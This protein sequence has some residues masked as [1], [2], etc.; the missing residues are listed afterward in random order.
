MANSSIIRKAK[1]KIVKDFIKDPEIIAAID[2]STIKPNEPEKLINTHIFNYNQN[3][4]TLNIVGTF[5][6]IQ[7]HIP[8]SYYHDYNASATRVKPTIEIWIVSHEKHMTVDNVPKVTQ[9]RN[10]YLSELIEKY[11][12]FRSSSYLLINSIDLNSVK[13]NSYVFSSAV[14]SGTLKSGYKTVD[15]YTTTYS[16][17]AIYNN[18]YP[19]TLADGEVSNFNSIINL[20]INTGNSY[21]GYNCYGL[22]GVLAGSVENINIVNTTITLAGIKQ[23]NE[24]VVNTIGTVCGLLEGGNISNVNVYSDIYLSK[25]KSATSTFLGTMNVGGICGTATDGIISSCTTNGTINKITYTTVGTQNHEHSIGGILGK[26]L[27]NDGVANC[28]NNIDINGINYQSNQNVTNYRQYVGGVIG[29]GEI[30]NA[31]ELQNNGEIYIGTTTVTNTKYSQ[32]YVA[33]VIG[34][35]ENATGTN[36]LYLNNSNIYYYVN[37]NNYKAYI[38]YA[39]SK[40]DFKDYDDAVAMYKKAIECNPAESN[41]YI[42]LGNLYSNQKCY[43]EAEEQYREALKI[44]KMDP[45][46]YVLLANVYFVPPLV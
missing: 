2:S 1:N 6:T 34:R 21:N 12:P 28:L 13:P 22:F 38:C 17:N 31:S 10:D 19:I 4:H 15:G 25:D 9:N 7:V 42:L 45:S 35:V 26:T 11:Q 44:N 20:D 32:T 46:I 39:I 8:Q 40:S 5:I 3:P 43:K 37:D 36:G 24:H 18:N 16:S 14:F 27:N 29:S 23:L 41:A 33:G 30:N